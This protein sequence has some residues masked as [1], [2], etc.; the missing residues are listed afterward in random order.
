MA[1]TEKNNDLKNKDN[2]YRDIYADKG[3][4]GSNLQDMLRESANSAGN[5]G[6]TASK[7]KK[8]NKKNNKKKSSKKRTLL[9]LARFFFCT[10]I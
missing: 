3:R 8:E 5:A 4:Y 2:R 6:K 10:L 7:S 9:F 1:G